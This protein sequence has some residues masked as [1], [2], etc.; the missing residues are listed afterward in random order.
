MTEQR[1]ITELKA[2]EVIDCRGTPTV[3]V[4]MWVDGVFRGRADVP[5]GRST[6]SYEAYELRDRESRYDGFG[7]L[8]AVKNINELISKEIIGLDVT[9][10]RKLDNL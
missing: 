6:G 2:R 10:Q 3:E 5:S 1:K 4:D 7:V 8:K 9:Q